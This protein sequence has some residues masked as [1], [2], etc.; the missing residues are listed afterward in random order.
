MATI[1]HHPTHY[2]SRHKSPP[3][4]ISNQAAYNRPVTRVTM[5]PPEIS[6]TEASYGSRSGGTFSARSSLYG[7]SQST[8]SE[9]DSYRSPRQPGVDVMDML[10]EKMNHA[11]DPIRMDR[12]MAHQTQMSGG[13][14]SKNREL[15]NMQKELLSRSKK[16]RVDFDEAVD[17]HRQA[18]RD[19]EYLQSKSKQMKSKAE[20]KHPEA[21]AKAS[22]SRH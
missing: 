20:K 9:Y 8:G 19:I 16:V 11:F 12:S 15:E 22:R 10:S 1:S 17:A 6:D 3:I 13:L 4:Y 5:T 2:E 18:R 21:Y 7:H 14:N